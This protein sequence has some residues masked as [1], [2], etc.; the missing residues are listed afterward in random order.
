MKTPEEIKR[1]LQCRVHFSANKGCCG[2]PA[3][4]DQCDAYADDHTFYTALQGY[5]HLLEERIDGML[6]QMA[7]DCGVCKHNGDTERCVTCLF[8]KDHTHPLWEY[9]GF[10]TDME[11][12]D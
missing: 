6:L 1:E 7:G 5:V 3:D 4:G 11:K 10:P 9:E 12:E 2:C 8:D